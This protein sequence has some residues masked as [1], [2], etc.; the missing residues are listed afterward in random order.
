MKKVSLVSRIL[1]GI[2]FTITG[3]NGFFNFL[4]FPPPTTPAAIMFM[5]GLV[6]SGYFFPFLKLVELLCG[7]MLLTG[8]FVP[9]ALIIISPVV[10]NIFMYHRCAAG[11]FPIDLILCA[12]LVLSA[13][14]YKDVFKLFFYRK[15]F[16]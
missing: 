8:S 4:P 12:L 13:L 15:I 10:V 3:L 14:N 7:L 9:L 1:L 16:Y 11:G 5:T 6:G 2:I